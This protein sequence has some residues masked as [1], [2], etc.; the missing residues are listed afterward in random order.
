MKHIKKILFVLS[1]TA[2]V[3]GG[4]YYY[5]SLEHGPIYD[6]NYERDR[7]DILDLFKKNWYWLSADSAYSPDYALQYRTHSR[8]PEAAGKMIIKV[9]RENN[10]F[11]GFTSYYPETTDKWKLLFVAVK[12][13]LR[14]KRYAQKLIEYG[15]EDMKK[16]GAKQIRLVTRPSN[17]SAQ[18]LYKRIGFYITSQEEEFVYFAYDAK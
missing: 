2:A 15:I 4:I 5:T 11:I 10:K 3:A 6:L 16:R 17:I 8:A 7:N 18:K 12:E 9:L 1:I 13:E 14:G